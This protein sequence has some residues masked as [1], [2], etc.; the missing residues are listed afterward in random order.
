LWNSRSINCSGRSDVP[1]YREVWAV[2][3]AQYSDVLC[4]Y[5]VA[6]SAAGSTPSLTCYGWNE[7]IRKVPVQLV[8][9]QHLT[10]EESRACVIDQGS[11]VCWGSAYGKVAPPSQLIDVKRLALGANHACAIDKF[12][13]ICWGDLDNERQPP[14]GLE[15]AG[16][17]VDVS[18]GENRSCAVLDDASV[19]CWGQK[20]WSDDD[21]PTGMKSR[22]ILGRSQLFC[23]TDELSPAGLRCWGGSSSLPR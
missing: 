7:E 22:L 16:R 13:L 17:V 9:P 20:G 4:I 23:A 8:D 1:A 3:T 2:A 10:V 21:P 19:Q 14:G 15:E 12:G 11:L 5:G 18:V 6:E